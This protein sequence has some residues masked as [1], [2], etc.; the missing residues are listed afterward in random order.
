MNGHSKKL[1]PSG[2]QQNGNHHSSWTKIEDEKL[3][4]ASEG[5]DEYWHF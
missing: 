3:V 4:K 2:G 1:W 5:G